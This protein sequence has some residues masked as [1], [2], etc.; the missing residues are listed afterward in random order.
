M[1][2]APTNDLNALVPPD[3]AVIGGRWPRWNVSEEHK[4]GWGI[5][6]IN[7]IRGRLNILAIEDGHTH[8]GAYDQETAFRIIVLTDAKPTREL[9]DM[10]QG[11]N[12]AM[13]QAFSQ[14]LKAKRQ[15]AERGAGEPAAPDQRADVKFESSSGIVQNSKDFLH[16]DHL[17]RDHPYLHGKIV[18]KLRIQ[19][20]P[21][22]NDSRKL[23]SQAPVDLFSLRQAVDPVPLFDG[24]AWLP[25]RVI[26]ETLRLF[27]NTSFSQK[28]EVVRRE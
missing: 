15:K 3:H 9:Q 6:A 28:Q 4:S 11:Y 17:Y 27:R 10:V 13:H 25:L 14:R 7:A 2:I 20:G 19:G 1:S 8:E 5:G 23:T 12:L 21:P 18:L 26:Q 16:W 24:D 22:E